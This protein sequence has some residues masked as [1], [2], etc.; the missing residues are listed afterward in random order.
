VYL[1]YARVFTLTYSSSFKKIN[2]VILLPSFFVVA[3]FDE[4]AAAVDV[5]VEV[6][7]FGRYDKCPSWREPIHCWDALEYIH[8]DEPGAAGI[9]LRTSGRLFFLR[10]LIGIL[11]VILYI[12]VLFWKV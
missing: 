4:V 5:D 6:F 1:P 7:V 8:P 11:G 9:P 12:F 3:A 2:L 10:S